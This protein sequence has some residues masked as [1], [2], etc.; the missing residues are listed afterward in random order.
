LDDS[1]GFFLGDPEYY[2]ED[3]AFVKSIVCDIK[4][5]PSFKTASSNRVH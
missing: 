3:E 1:V 4:A 2:R 5:E